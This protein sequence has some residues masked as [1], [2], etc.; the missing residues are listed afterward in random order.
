MSDVAYRHLGLHDAADR[1]WADQPA[2]VTD[3]IG[4]YVDGFNTELNDEGASGWCHGEPW[5][6]PI[7]R[8]DLYAYFSDAVLF[9]SGGR[10]AGRDRTR[11]AATRRHDRHD[12]DRH[13]C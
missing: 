13:R 3:F 10:A 5:V 7:T 8:T 1:R 2:D 4:G 9:A 12:N 11:A 6:Q